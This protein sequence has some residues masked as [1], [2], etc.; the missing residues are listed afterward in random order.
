MNKL[1]KIATTGLAALVLSLGAS[2]CG[3]QG[4]NDVK[5]EQVQ[6]SSNLRNVVLSYLSQPNFS[7]SDFME[8]ITGTRVEME[9][10]NLNEDM[11][12]LGFRGFDKIIISSSEQIPI[13]N[14]SFNA[15]TIYY[16]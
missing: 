1:R 15:I 14:F 3:E 10:W 11:L 16:M 12:K 5:T 9:K 8:Q 4:A 6:K 2:G 7:G 13:R